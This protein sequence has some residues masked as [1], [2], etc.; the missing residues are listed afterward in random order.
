[1][2]QTTDDVQFRRASIVRGTGAFENLRPVHDVG[3]GVVE[4]GP[5]RAKVAL[6]DA[7]VRR[8]DMRVDVVIAKLAVVP[9]AD[10]VGHLAD[11]E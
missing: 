11:R 9:F 3:A 2:V 8:V 1:M 4:V 5:E 10:E 7:D 6:V